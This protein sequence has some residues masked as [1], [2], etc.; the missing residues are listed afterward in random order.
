MGRLS[1]LE[2]ALSRGRL[3]IL[4]GLPLFLL[5]L[6]VWFRP[7]HH[8]AKVPQT[9][10][11]E[12]RLPDDPNA[13][14]QAY[15]PELNYTASCR[16]SELGRPGQPFHWTVQLPGPPGKVQMQTVQGNLPP[17]SGV[18]VGVSGHTVQVSPPP[19]AAGPTEVAPAK[20]K[21]HEIQLARRRKRKE[22]LEQRLNKLR[23]RHPRR[24]R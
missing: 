7:T 22:R 18:P 24:R 8:A 10:T 9:L 4:V 19:A 12:G 13:Q 11:L 5:G 2:S 14:V 21:N 20:R 15:F 16:A 3:A 23:S 17:L 1:G 6:M